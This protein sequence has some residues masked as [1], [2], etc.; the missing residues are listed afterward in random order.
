MYRT[1]PANLLHL[2]PMYQRFLVHQEAPSHHHV[3]WF[4]LF[5]VHRLLLK[6]P[7]Y[8]SLLSYLSYRLYQ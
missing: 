4:H 7:K 5:L 6:Y 1:F 2:Y 3:H 8:H